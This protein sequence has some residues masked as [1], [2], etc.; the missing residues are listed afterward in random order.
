MSPAAQHILDAEAEHIRQTFVNTLTNTFPDRYPDDPSGPRLGPL[1]HP[2]VGRYLDSALLNDAA[3]IEQSDALSIGTTLPDLDYSRPGKPGLVV[4]E[5]RSFGDHPF[6]DLQQLDAQYRELEQLVSHVVAE[7]ERPPIQRLEQ[8]VDAREAADR[9]G[10]ADVLSLEDC[11]ERAGEAF[12]AM[13]GRS[14]NIVSADEVVTRPS[15]GQ[16]VSMLGGELIDVAGVNSVQLAAG[17][18]D[19][20]ML[21]VYRPADA[22]G[23]P[24]HVYWLVSDDRAWPSTLRWVDTQQPGLFAETATLHDSH[25]AALSRPGTQVLKLDATGHPVE[26]TELVSGEAS[27]LVDALV[28]PSP[29]RRRPGAIGFEIELA[30]LAF[31]KRDRRGDE[32]DEG[33][34]ATAP[35]VEL[36]L[37]WTAFHVGPGGKIVKGLGRGTEERPALPIVEVISEPIAILPGEVGIPGRVGA[38]QAFADL[39]NVIEAFSV[40]PIAMEG[41]L[42]T[43]GVKLSELWL[44]DSGFT[45]SEAARDV[46]VLQVEGFADQM[47]VQYTVGVPLAGIQPFFQWLAD[48]G[49]NRASDRMERLEQSIP[50]GDVVGSR[51]WAWRRMQVAQLSERPS[52]AQLALEMAAIKGFAALVYTQVAATLDQA[53]GGG[54][55]K[56]H[57]FA[58]LRNPMAAVRADL[59]EAVREYLNDQ[60]AE[61][62]AL[63]E[64]SLSSKLDYKWLNDTDPD[65]PYSISEY[66]DNALLDVPSR[67]MDQEQALGMED[68]KGYF[69]QLDNVVPGGLPLVLLEL[70]STPGRGSLAQQSTLQQDF[71]QLTDQLRKSYAAAVAL[72]NAAEPVPPPGDTT[73]ADRGQAGGMPASSDLRASDDVSDND[74][75]SSLGDEADLSSVDD[76]H[77]NPS[78][79]DD[80]ASDL[81]DGGGMSDNDVRW[82]SS[83]PEG[84]IEW[85]AGEG[86]QPSSEDEGV[87]GRSPDNDDAWPSSDEEDGDLGVGAS[88]GWANPAGRAGTWPS[89]YLGAESGWRDGPPPALNGDPAWLAGVNP[90]REEGG[91]FLTNCVLAAMATDMALQDRGQFRYQVPPSGPLALADLVSYANDSARGRGAD[92]VRLGFVAST[93]GTLRDGLADAAPWSRG[94]VVVDGDGPD[95]PAHVVNVVRLGQE[96]VFV[97]GQL[98]RA[99][100]PPDDAKVLF[101]PLTDGIEVD[102]AAV[103]GG[104]LA[105]REAAGAGFEAET[106]TSLVLPAH[107]TETQIWGLG[108]LVQGEGVKIVVD[109]GPQGWIAEVVSEPAAVLP[110]ETSKVSIARALGAAQVA[111]A[112]LNDGTGRTLRDAF[113]G[114]PGF[115]VQPVADQITVGPKQRARAPGRTAEKEL[116]PHYT[117]GVPIAGLPE[118]L[119]LAQTEMR[120]QHAAPVYAK[121]QVRNALNFAADV[122]SDYRRGVTGD[123]QRDLD[124]AALTGFLALTYT[125]VAAVVG[126]VV[127]KDVGPLPKNHALAASRTALSAVREALPPTVRQF[128]EAN[129]DGLIAMLADHYVN[130]SQAWANQSNFDLGDITKIVWESAKNGQNFTVEEYLASAFGKSGEI[131]DQGTALEIRTNMTTLDTD[132]P[133]MPLVVVELRW[134]GDDFVSFD[135]LEKKFDSLVDWA[136]SLMATIDQAQGEQARAEAERRARA[137]AE[138]QVRAEAERR[139][140]AEAERQVRAEAERRARADAERQVRAEAER[141]ARV[142]AEQARVEAER[143]AWIEAERDARRRA[144]SARAEAERRARAETE[145]RAVEPPLAEEPSGSQPRRRER[146]RNWLGSLGPSNRDDNGDSGEPPGTGQSSSGP[147]RQGGLGRFLNSQAS[148]GPVRGREVD[149]RFPWLG[150]INPRWREGGEFGTNCVVAA[151]AADMTLADVDGY[152]YQAPSS[153]PTRATD[154]V[155][156]ANDRARGIAPDR[157]PFGFIAVSDPEAVRLAMAVAPPWSRGI[158][159]SVDSDGRAHVINVVTLDTPDPTTDSG[160]EVAFLDAQSGTRAQLPP[161][162]VELYFLPLT[163]GIEVDG[164][165]VDGGVLADREAAGAGFEAETLT[166][167]EMPEHWSDEEIWG[168]GTLVQGDGVKIVVDAGPDGWIAEVV[169]EPAAVLPNE[170]SKVSVAKALDAAYTALAILASGEGKTLSEAFRGYPNFRLQPAAYEIS[171]GPQ[172]TT[173]AQGRSVER[174]LFTHFTVGVP[175]SGLVELLEFAVENSTGKGVRQYGERQVRAALDFADKIENVYLRRHGNVKLDGTDLDVDALRGFLALTYTQVGAIVAGIVN[176]RVLPKNNMLAVS[177][178]ALSA[179]R[180]ALPPKVRQFVESNADEFTAMLSGHYVA[181]NQTWAQKYGFEIGDVASLQWDSPSGDRTFS[182]GEYL[183]SAFGSSGELIDQG[184]ALEIRTNM[185]T[186]DTDIP[187]MPLVVVELRW[188]GERFRSF[189]ELERTYD[190]L[191]DWASRLMTNIDSEQQAQASSQAE[192]ARAQAAREAAVRRAQATVRGWPTGSERSWTQPRSRELRR[193]DAGVER[194]RAAPSTEALRELQQAIAAWSDIKQGGSSRQVAVDALRDAVDIL[195]GGQQPTGRRDTSAAD[196]AAA[197]DP[198]NTGLRMHAG[199]GTPPTVAELLGALNAAYAPNA[200]DVGGPAGPRGSETVNALGPDYLGRRAAAPA[201]EFL[202]GYNFRNLKSWQRSAF[203]ASVSLTRDTPPRAADLTPGRLQ[204]DDRS[205]VAA[206]E[207][208]DVGRMRS[209]KGRRIPRIIH[210]IW[211]GGP[212][213]EHGDQGAFR[214]NLEHHA[215]A[216]RGYQTVLWTDVTRAEIAA[217]R[218][219][220]PVPAAGTRA[221]EVLHMVDWAQQHGI[222]LVNVDEIFTQDNPMSTEALYKSELVKGVGPGY[223]AASDLLRMEILERFGGVYSDGDNRLRVGEDLDEWLSRAATE[224]LGFAFPRT[225]GRVTNATVIAAAATGLGDAYAASVSDNYTRDATS[226]V[227][228]GQSV[229]GAVAATMSHSYQRVRLITLNRTGP[230]PN[231][232]NSVAEHFGWARSHELPDAMDADAQAAAERALDE[233]ARVSAAVG[234][235]ERAAAQAAQ[236]AEMAQTAAESAAEGP[237]KAELIAE[238]AAQARRARDLAE[239][240]DRARLIADRNAEEQAEAAN[241]FRVESQQAWLHQQPAPT[242]TVDPHTTRQRVLDVASAL[243]TELHDNPGNL[244]LALVQSAVERDANPAVVWDTVIEFLA[245]HDQIR[246]MVTTVSFA[247]VDRAGVPGA[248]VQLPARARAFLAPQAA[249]SGGGTPPDRGTAGTPASARRGRPGA[250]G[251]VVAAGDDG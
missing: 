188:F 234:N 245:S 4:V 224:P 211:L 201:P 187:G 37:D 101:L 134:F 171:I 100:V 109:A 32:E 230:S 141:R 130:W 148:G 237:G 153:G 94:F 23:R 231:V 55:P 131:I 198:R 108:T 176:G 138:R 105:D 178:T 52:G 195:L 200:V 212:L 247:F 185:T 168:L 147:S 173:M 228:R 17:M 151:I 205:V 27:R 194:F 115:V 227:T 202:R 177:R 30:V 251:A 9:E 28:D 21:L 204:R 39:M 13:H 49:E 42:H 112:A 43:S 36:A 152:A 110:G 83:N 225:D 60:S 22:Y 154:L 203:F 116:F 166:S 117:V 223:A 97:D 64:W 3:Q 54:L 189:S 206:R 129:A 10:R 193:I 239:E 150:L 127:N 244:N 102:G 172:Q 57:A 78:D 207:L 19:G 192:Q 58:V 86:G 219:G 184:T 179:V 240:A 163:D 80:D 199:S 11:L 235:I 215:R 157:E 62:R 72:K 76:D 92:Q 210:S 158:L 149:A 222:Q 63:F 169:S 38:E 243:I 77:D 70:R 250:V 6:L 248:P 7:A 99:V 118:L 71:A 145:R 220:Q 164:A 214:R 111:M 53:D 183:A 229:A 135:G 217:A 113:D 14:G 81:D 1:N 124:V 35:G 114:Y 82:L 221:A 156:Y 119:S 41:H 232:F 107:W 15:L 24:A 161:A 46:Q 26:I 126:G 162:G 170:T 16:F 48:Q 56:N 242:P 236:A 128:V 241:P 69:Q 144:E 103:D 182:V 5:L 174:D 12:H 209:F 139:A 96:V 34:L 68:P 33:T 8:W 40:T 89:G 51:Y 246:R 79:V 2:D 106:L 50:F 88:A 95:R 181:W 44:E 186:L 249:P 191:V 146:I 75:T 66:I 25:G 180:E 104:V 20:E 133:D 132:L 216:S 85:S 190:D 233:Q 159:G 120:H 122:A 226:L 155:A 140:R 84:G 218:A 47:Y 18:A 125:Q 98:G 121:Y 31:G 197:Y 93:A 160:R 123:D 208:R 91:D 87:R 61:V 90:L 73:V 143:Q 213:G 137:D 65:N 45:L 167:L 29:G 136:W 142:Q 196:P 175:V 59:P 74:D 67:P 238:A 165:A